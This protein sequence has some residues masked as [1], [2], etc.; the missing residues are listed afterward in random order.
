MSGISG[1]CRDDGN[2]CQISGFFQIP[3]GL[4]MYDIV[5]VQ[6]VF[7]HTKVKVIQKSTLTKAT[8]DAFIQI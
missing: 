8:K 1:L 3:P 6:L 4:H 7:Q 2:S 5:V